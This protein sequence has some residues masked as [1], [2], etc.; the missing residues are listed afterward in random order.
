L[1]LL[2]VLDQI[3][4]ALLHPDL[5][6]EEIGVGRR[7]GDSRRRS[8]S[9]KHPRVRSEIVER[10]TATSQEFL[11]S[12]SNYEGFYISVPIALVKVLAA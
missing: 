9:G 8:V 10:R 1:E 3:R 6:R 11:R 7:K 5:E 2:R 12:N 4:K